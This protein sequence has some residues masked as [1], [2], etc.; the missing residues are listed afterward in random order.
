MPAGLEPAT[1]WLTATRSTIEL[2]QIL[3][4][5]MGFEPTYTRSVTGLAN[6]RLKPLGHL[7]LPSAAK[8]EGDRK[9]SR[10]AK[11]PTR[12]KGR[13]S[14]KSSIQTGIDQNRRPGWAKPG[15]ADRAGYELWPKAKKPKPNQGHRS[16]QGSRSAEEEFGPGSRCSWN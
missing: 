9:S 16:A 7:L 11:N 12:G 5:R 14:K 8:S 6:R 3:M 10:M 13:K 15:R 1:K 4:G 2:R